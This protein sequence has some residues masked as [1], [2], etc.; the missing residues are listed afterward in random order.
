MPVLF[1]HGWGLAQH[2]YKRALKR[3]VRLGCRVYAP[4]LPGFG[5]TADLPG[6]ALD[7]PGYAAWVRAFLD[8][9][10]VEES[11]F[12]I[13]HSFGG[14][15]SIQLAHDHLE[16]VSYLV[17]INSVGGGTWLEGGNRV[18]T[19]ADRPLWD[20]LLTFPG[21]V[22]PVRSLGQFSRVTLE[23]F[24]P[25]ILHNP[26][27]IWRVGQLARH[28]DLAAELSDLRASGI[29][30]VALRGDQDNVIPKA[31][32]D[33]LCAALGSTGEVVHGRHSWLLTDPDTF[34]EVLANSVAVARAA[35]DLGAGGDAGLCEA[36]GA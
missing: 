8:A 21:D 14:A 29:P 9:V 27:G 30:L 20:W 11:V 2:S 18:R 34:G 7:L 28:L 23:D 24:L 16:R 10:G 13:G 5:G 12:V 35:R 6:E 26:V 17:L 19:M 33:A 32:F 22:L 3:L 1:L 31:S 36:P 15:V 4:A 25:N